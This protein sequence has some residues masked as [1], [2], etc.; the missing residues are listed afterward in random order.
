MEQKL[1][2]D[3][4]TLRNLEKFQEPGW[5]PFD[6]KVLW[7]G[8]RQKGY[9]KIDR[10]DLPLMSVITVVRNGA[11]TIRETLESVFIQ[12]YENIELIVVDGASDD[13]TLEILR[14]NE[15]MIDL[16]ISGQDEGIYD[17]MN[18]GLELASGRYIHFLN[19]DDHYSF[20]GVLKIISDNF[21]KHNC[22]LINSNV[23]MLNPEKGFGWVRHSNVSK[24]YYLFKG[25]PQQAF[26]YEKTLFEDF[27]KF[28]TQFP[29][30][31]D[32]EFLLR[33]IIKYGVKQRYVNMPAVVFL[34]GG[35][36]GDMERKKQERN[37]V[38]KKY[39]PG[40]SFI[41]LRNSCFERLLTRNEMRGKKKNTVEKFLG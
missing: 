39:F 11:D 38:L 18:K 31:A 17:A 21:R 35:I 13:G 4:S 23:L 41:F 16:W 7:G 29:V 30:V 1:R 36:S 15:M 28:D 19:A 24:Y 10:E 37:S 2:K 3:T 32:L 40:W 22:R 8:L 9:Q 33:L 34:S 12:S 26:F 14:E 5:R 25:V 6:G 27:G 20:N